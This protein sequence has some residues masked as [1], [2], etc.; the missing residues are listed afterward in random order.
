MTGINLCNNFYVLTHWTYLNSNTSFDLLFVF[1][2]FYFSI[3]FF[4]LMIIIEMGK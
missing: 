3:S 4:F 1:V 2:S